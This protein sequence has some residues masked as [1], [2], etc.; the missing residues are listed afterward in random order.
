M[1]I[2]PSL[3]ALVLIDDGITMAGDLLSYSVANGY[4]CIS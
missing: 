1:R 3:T 4:T 2:A